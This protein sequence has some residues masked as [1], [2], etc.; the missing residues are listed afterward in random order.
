LRFALD[1]STV[2]TDGAAQYRMTSIARPA[3]DIT[4][5]SYSLHTL[6]EDEAPR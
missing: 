6:A 3:L 5:A 4:V 2:G 1:G